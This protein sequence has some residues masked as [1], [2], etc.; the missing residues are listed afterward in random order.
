MRAKKADGFTIEKQT[1]SNHGFTYD[2]YLL[3]GWLNGQRVRRQFKNRTEAFH[4]KTELEIEAANLDGNTRSRVTRLSESQLAEAEAA[5]TRLGGKSLSGAVTWYLETYRPP[6][7][8]KPF[9]D[10]ITAFMADRKKRVSAVVFKNYGNTTKWLEAAFPS[11]C[12]HEITTADIQ[13]LL[14]SRDVGKKRFN[15]LRGDLH[16][17]FTFCQRA[18]QQWIAENPVTPI[19]AFKLTHA[20]P[21]IITAQKAA[22]LMEY[23]EAYKGGENSELAA[24]CLVPYFALALFAGLRP[25]VKEGEIAKLA[26][27]PDPSKPI[28]LE[29]GAIR[30][31]PEIS[32]VKRVR[33]VTIQPNLAA[34]L[35]RYPIKKFPIIPPN[36]VRMI[37]EIKIKFG[38]GHDV[39][40]HTFISMHCGKFQSMGAAALQA[41]N[42]ERMIR[43]HYY[44]TVSAADAEAFWAIEPGVKTGEVIEI[45]A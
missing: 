45:T 31:E 3:R 12:V 23:V 39:L 33:S 21:E 38:I 13:T 32:K 43:D 36:A 41:G 11:K 7:T 9:G 4:A 5:F 27:L 1:L 18:P 16:T 35:M 14:A 22:Q 44:N 25:S 10:A 37:R 6:S 34:W 42:S 30:I 40:R 15:N 28:N 26:K 19:P 20:S 17:I 24:G 2:S 29:L 8:A